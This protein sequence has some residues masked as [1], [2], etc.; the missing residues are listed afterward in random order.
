MSTFVSR[1]PG[2]L[3]LEGR[4]A[5]LLQEKEAVSIATYMER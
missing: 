1:Q 3:K 5:Q 2:A 4:L